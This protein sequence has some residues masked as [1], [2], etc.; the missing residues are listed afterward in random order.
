MIDDA[1]MRQ[2]RHRRIVGALLAAVVVSAGLIAG[3][4]GGGGAG[5]GAGRHADGRLATLPAH[6]QRAFAERACI[7]KWTPAMHS[8]S[9]VLVA[10]TRGPVTLV[11]LTSSDGSGSA[12][13]IATPQVVYITGGSPPGPGDGP[14]PAS[15][16]RVRPEEGGG[17]FLGSAT[18]YEPTDRR[19]SDI[20]GT[21]GAGVRALTLILL[22]GQRV[23]PTIEN[24]SFA[25]WWP[26]RVFVRT[27]EV[28][29][30]RGTRSCFRLRSA[31]AAIGLLRRSRCT[32]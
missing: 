30:A 13:C 31:S 3:V 26:S 23:I 27:Y 18:G 29:T 15:A 1:R 25:A 32:V 2:R 24:G 5:G 16:G 10:D 19:F 20:E 4:G 17:G 28:E 22:N 14:R 8:P 12:T 9:H 7:A 11:I 6:G 21:V